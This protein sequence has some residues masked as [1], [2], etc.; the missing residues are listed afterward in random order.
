MVVSGLNAK[1]F[2]EHAGVI[3]QN[4]NFA[5]KAAY[6]RALVES[7]P[8]DL[9]FSRRNVLGSLV[10]EKQIAVVTP[11]VVSVAVKTV[12][13]RPTPEAAPPASTEVP[14]P[15]L[16]GNYAP[17]RGQATVRYT[18][19]VTRHQGDVVVTRISVMN[20]SNA[21]IER[22][23]IDETWYDKR[24]NLLPGGRAVLNRLDPGEAATMTIQTPFDGR[25]SKNNYNFT[26]ANGT[27]R[28]I[29]AASLP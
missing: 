7:L 1:F 29:A 20:V 15:S 28:P 26:H 8:E 4:V 12:E 11:F 9:F 6:L 25:M 24:G 10:L 5:I 16:H 17:F 23:T 13:T 18:K 14:R 27:V 21:P 2:Y 3:P 22:L 19:P